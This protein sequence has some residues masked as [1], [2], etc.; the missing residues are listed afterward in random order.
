MAMHET[1]TRNARSP[2][3]RQGEPMAGERDFSHRSLVEKLGVRAGSRVSVLGMA[4]AGFLEQLRSAG[5]D[6]SVGRRRKQS[7]L[8]FLAVESMRELRRIGSLEPS[9]A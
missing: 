3:G 8:I 9:M 4:E 7:D 6:L 2:R 5:A 1:A